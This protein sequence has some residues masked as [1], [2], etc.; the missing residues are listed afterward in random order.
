MSDDAK[1]SKALAMSVALSIC[2]GLHGWAESSDFNLVLQ[3][4]RHLLCLVNGN[5]DK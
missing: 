5:G 2:E 3:K 1:K 4:V